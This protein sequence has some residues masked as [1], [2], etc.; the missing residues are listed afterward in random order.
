MNTDQFL[1][2]LACPVVPVVVVEQVA[3]A[4]PLAEALF[5]GGVSA[6]E[7]T[8]RTEIG[9]EAMGAIK[10]AFPDQLVGAGTV[11][12]SEQFRSAIDRGADFIVSPGAA[13]ALFDTAAKYELPFL[14]GA[15]TGSEIMTALDRGY[16]TLKFFPA[17]ASGGAAAIKA[18][19]GPFGDLTFMPTGGITPDNLATYLSVNSVVAV[20]GSWL[21]P[22]GLLREGQWEAIYQLA[23]EAVE[24]CAS[25]R[26]EVQQ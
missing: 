4:V 24:M 25:L 17:E 6:L 16:R 22:R 9:L 18:F 2:R 11:L 3:H 8:L 12:N 1:A 20:G 5:S 13:D 14:P 23:R 19:S 26:S 15:V 7:I 21:T 10:A